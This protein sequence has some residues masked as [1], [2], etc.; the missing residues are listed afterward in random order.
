MFAIQPFETL[1]SVITGFY[2]LTHVNNCTC[3]LL[4]SSVPCQH[5]VVDI[6]LDKV[7]QNDGLEFTGIPE[8]VPTLAEYL[9]E[10]CAV[11]VRTT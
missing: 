3:L 9:A 2:Y 6:S 5:Y 10:Y 11:T 7:E 8:G 4:L 1:L